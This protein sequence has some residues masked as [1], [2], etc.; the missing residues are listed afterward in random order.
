MEIQYF[1]VPVHKDNP[2]VGKLLLNKSPNL[3]NST[4]NVSTLYLN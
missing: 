2:A 3:I 4:N 1:I